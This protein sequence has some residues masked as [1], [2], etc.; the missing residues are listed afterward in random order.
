MNGT[1]YHLRLA[2]GSIATKGAGAVSE[3]SPIAKDGIHVKDVYPWQGARV[4]TDPKF[5]N[6]MKTLNELFQELTSAAREEGKSLGRRL[7]RF[8]VAFAEMEE[9]ASEKKPRI[10]AQAKKTVEAPEPSKSKSKQMVLGAET[11]PSS[12]MSGPAAMDAPRRPHAKA[13]PKRSGYKTEGR[14]KE[15]KL[16]PSEA[17]GE[18]GE[19]PIKQQESLSEL[20]L[21]NYALSLGWSK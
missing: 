6:S 21:K 8:W 13:S 18:W 2:T 3:A 11:C 16:P 12:T 7:L 15:A 20:S 17:P 9:K 5:R 14:Q 10:H 19:T 4:N 1:S